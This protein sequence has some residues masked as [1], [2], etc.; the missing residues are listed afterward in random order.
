MV[1]TLPNGAE[2]LINRT[3]KL[4]SK[5]FPTEEDARINMGLQRYKMGLQGG[6]DWLHATEYK[7]ASNNACISIFKGDLFISYIRDFL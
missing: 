2:V 7:K 3:A 1:S 4:T 5:K 6:G